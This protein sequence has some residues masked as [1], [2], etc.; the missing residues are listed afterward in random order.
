MNKSVLILIVTAWASLTATA[1]DRS[2]RRAIRQPDADFIRKYDRNGDG[3]LD[4]DETAA[5][6]AELKQNKIKRKGSPPPPA[7]PGLAAPGVPPVPTK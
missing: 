3:K 1:A 4:K 2:E 7:N 5:A 6:R